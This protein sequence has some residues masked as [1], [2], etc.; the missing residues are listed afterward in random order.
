[1]HEVTVFRSLCLGR[2]VQ[3]AVFRS[4]R[5]GCL[6]GFS[7]P[8]E[9]HGAIFSSL[10]LSNCLDKFCPCFTLQR[11]RFESFLMMSQKFEGKPRKRTLIYV[12]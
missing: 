9:L 3:V 2:C 5:F 12:V 6:H 10:L 7:N 8:R 1:M 11:F 4:P